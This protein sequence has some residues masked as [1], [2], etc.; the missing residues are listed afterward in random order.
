MIFAFITLAL[1][2][3]MI[4]L[5]LYCLR[6]GVIGTRPGKDIRRSTQP[7]PYWFGMVALVLGTG[8]SMV[9]GGVALWSLVAHHGN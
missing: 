6:N 9:C 2:A 8:F 4:A 1:A 3:G 5:L 7:I